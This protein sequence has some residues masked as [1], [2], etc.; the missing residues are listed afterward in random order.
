MSNAHTFSKARNGY[1]LGTG[2]FWFDDPW[3]FVGCL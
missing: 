3:W 2:K 1:R